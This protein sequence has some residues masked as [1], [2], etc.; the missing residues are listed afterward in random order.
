MYTFSLLS[1]YIAPSFDLLADVYTQD[2]WNP[3]GLN[4]TPGI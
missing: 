3:R 2:M 1:N 4:G